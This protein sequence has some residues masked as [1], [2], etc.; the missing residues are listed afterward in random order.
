MK[1][2]QHAFSKSRQRDDERKSI[3]QHFGFLASR[4][5]LICVAM[6]KTPMKS[7]LSLIPLTSFSPNKLVGGSPDPPGNGSGTHKS[8]VNE[9][10]SKH[11]PHKKSMAPLDSR[12]CLEESV[13]L[14]HNSVEEARVDGIAQSLDEA[15]KEDDGQDEN[16]DTAWLLNMFKSLE[17]QHLDEK[18]DWE[19][20]LKKER[21]RK[22]SY[23]SQLKGA[24]Q[25]KL[26][27]LETQLQKVGEN[28]CSDGKEAILRQGKILFAAS[29]D[30]S[31]GT[32]STS[33]T[34]EH[35]RGE[36]QI[37]STPVFGQGSLS[38]ALSPSSLQKVQQLEQTLHHTLRQYETDRAAWVKALEDAAAV[39]QAGEKL[40][41]YQ[42]QLL[43][44][45]KKQLADEQKQHKK[46]WKEQNNVLK[47][48][49]TLT[50]AQFEQEKQEWERQASE[51]RRIQ[52]KERKQAREAEERYKQDLNEMM[53]ENQ[54]ILKD[55]IDLE[56]SL[57]KIEEEKA[58]MSRQII[59][60]QKNLMETQNDR[61]V[62]AD[63]AHHRAIPSPGHVDW[64]D[65][66]DRA[67]IERDLYKQEASQA[68]ENLNV[69]R[70]KW[71]EHSEKALKAE[72]KEALDR[73]EKERKAWEEKLENKE[74]ECA[75]IRNG[76]ETE[77]QQWADKQ[78]K[79]IKE[80]EK[81][82]RNQIEE[83][84]KLHAVELSEVQSSD[85]E[86]AGKCREAVE[87][88]NEIVLRLRRIEQQRSEEKG[89]WKLQLEGALSESRR[90][91]MTVQQ[92][93]KE[94][95]EERQRRTD[96]TESLRDDLSRT[97]LL[98]SAK[99]IHD[100]QPSG[101]TEHVMKLHEQ[102]VK[103]REDT[104][105]QLAVMR[106]SHARDVQRL[107]GELEIL[108]SQN[109]A[110]V[111]ELKR[112]K[113]IKNEVNE[114]GLLMKKSHENLSSEF[115]LAIRGKDDDIKKLKS[116]LEELECA[117][118]KVEHDAI[119][120]AAKLDSSRK[121][122]KQAEEKLK[123]TKEK[124]LEEAAEKAVQLQDAKE[125]LCRLKE[126]M[127]EV[128]KHLQNVL[129]EKEGFVQR[130]LDLTGQIDNLKERLEK[131][132]KKLC[133]TELLDERR[134]ECNTQ[135]LFGI[136][137]V[138][139]NLIDS[140]ESRHA[141]FKERMELEIEKLSIENDNFRVGKAEGHQNT[142]LQIAV[143]ELRQDVVTIRDIMETTLR[144]DK[145]IGESNFD[146]LRANLEQ[147]QNNLDDVVGEAALQTESMYEFQK[148]AKDHL[149][150]ANIA[151]GNGLLLELQENL[152]S[153]MAGLRD[154]LAEVI[155]NQSKLKARARVTSFLDSILTKQQSF[156]NPT[157]IWIN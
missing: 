132:L 148:L 68:A 92:L 13:R 16:K 125:S 72:R 142:K 71:E 22:F 113:K 126:Q 143:E 58:G 115:N 108:E 120:L 21:N 73:L 61:G 28:H 87:K 102:L 29:S 54:A 152:M 139:E 6:V 109:G 156:K 91:A 24:Y 50:E 122:T 135:S 39:T 80:W 45:L 32:A 118:D 47:D 153:E 30:E 78:D 41:T 2:T 31:A 84:Q 51:Y 63:I 35:E 66:L 74:K 34:G 14:L 57:E 37:M 127:H 67:M 101:M 10:K 124:L 111:C 23:K 15:I 1:C 42:E 19:K 60:L 11:S 155:Q 95:A 25:E 150:E 38:K 85:H 55:K 104:E 103:A 89:T 130:N 83:L 17:K 20:N 128:E 64:D 62:T 140:L 79:M 27:W 137:D 144:T 141:V 4:K 5:D 149:K 40:S 53:E 44:D 81:E 70:K 129:A 65:R 154:G 33:S 138:I 18:S 77:R 106:E 9:S 94:L 86:L 146:T 100:A 36:E 12:D 90:A 7:R 26:T 52:A 151:R 88:K 133:E 116:K 112:Q 99:N 59:Q 121:E 136:L 48:L 75:E 43:S 97:R 131:L 110:L 49:L 157:Q 46:K 119:E 107:M 93:K 114:E 96:E 82:T 98:L 134:P 3:T 56:Q 8:A 123:D 117:R 76:W 105:C 147:I 69:E 145:A